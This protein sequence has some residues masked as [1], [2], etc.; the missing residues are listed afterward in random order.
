MRELLPVPEASCFLSMLLLPKATDA[1][2]TR[3]NSLEDTLTRC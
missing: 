3:H 1:F 2:N